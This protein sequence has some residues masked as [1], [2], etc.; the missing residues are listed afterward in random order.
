MDAILRKTSACFLL[1]GCLAGCNRS[2]SSPR[3]AESEVSR[4]IEDHNWQPP[5]PTRDGE[6]LA[7]LT[8]LEVASPDRTVQTFL[9]S[10]RSGDDARARALLTE[11]ARAETSRKGLVVQP[12][13]SPDASYEIVGVK[14]A[15]TQKDTAEVTSV[16][17]EPTPSGTRSDRI[18]WIL[19]RAVQ[20]W[21]VS[22]MAMELVPGHAPQLLNFEDPDDME[23][24]LRTAEDQLTGRQ[25]S[26]DR[27]ESATRE[28]RRADSGTYGPR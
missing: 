8:A 19:R 6:E 23:H 27:Q 10:L 15:S 17:T 26:G 21:R 4:G 7:A 25:D 12:P 14:F 24:Q 18:T 5:A 16:W 11:K 2:D 20:G 22:G 13:G 9:D 1:V 3:M 28:A